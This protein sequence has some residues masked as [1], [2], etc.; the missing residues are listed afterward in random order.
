MKNNFLQEVSVSV[1][2]V[3]LLVLFL[4]PLGFWMSNTLL[5]MLMP[6]LVVVFVVF[7]SFVW[8]ESSRDEREGLHKMMAGKFA[9]LA[10]AGALIIGIIVQSL[11]H[12]LDGWL[13]F[14]LGAMILAKIVGLIYG[15]IKY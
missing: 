1:I 12:N 6:V 15:R 14:V 9:F 7:A 5:M 10:G 2:L 8:K 4:N 13:V 11:Q 3:V